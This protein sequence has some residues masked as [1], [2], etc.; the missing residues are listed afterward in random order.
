M[1]DPRTPPPLPP[2]PVS[3]PGSPQEVPPLPGSLPV[4]PATLPDAIRE[5]LLSE[6]VALF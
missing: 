3:G 2:R 6:H 4:D 5:E 1:S